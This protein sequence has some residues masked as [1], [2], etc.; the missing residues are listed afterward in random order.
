VEE[1]SG[2]SVVMGE[3]GGVEIDP[4]WDVESESTI[5]R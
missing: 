3:S 5:F 2:V 4:F 1:P